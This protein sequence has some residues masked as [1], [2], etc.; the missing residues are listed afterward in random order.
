MEAE[1]MDNTEQ[2]GPWWI[3]GWNLWYGESIAG[4]P[5]V[6]A[7]VDVPANLPKIR[8]TEV[9]TCMMAAVR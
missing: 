6:V 5:A 2:M 1:A 3:E 9:N 7:G 8:K 4:D